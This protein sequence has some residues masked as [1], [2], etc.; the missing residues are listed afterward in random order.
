MRL[1]TGRTWLLPIRVQARTVLKPSVRGFGHKFYLY[2]R[3]RPV[4][5]GDAPESSARRIDRIRGDHSS[6]SAGTAER[7][8]STSDISLGSRTMRRQG[9]RGC[10]DANDERIAR[11]HQGQSTL[12]YLVN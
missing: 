11:K 3:D 4:A 6:K 7:I 5:R 2:R 8:T 12:S 1:V 9:R 10:H